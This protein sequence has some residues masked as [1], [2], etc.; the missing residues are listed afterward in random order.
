MAFIQVNETVN[1]STSVCGIQQRYWR[2]I[3][4]KLSDNKK[5]NDSIAIRKGELISIKF[6]IS[7]VYYLT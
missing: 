7:M 4:I 2:S 6:F 1:V 5:I 3:K